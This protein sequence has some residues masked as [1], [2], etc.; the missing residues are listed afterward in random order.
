MHFGIKF[1]GYG[2]DGTP[3]TPAICLN[4]PIIA[5]NIYHIKLMRTNGNVAERDK[6]DVSKS[7]SI[8]INSGGTYD[9][10]DWFPPADI[11]KDEISY[12][13]ASSSL[14]I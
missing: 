12:F 8:V 6:S 1:N 7:L 3:I 11:F 13:N 14:A 4:I 10:I 9:Y 2:I 5:L